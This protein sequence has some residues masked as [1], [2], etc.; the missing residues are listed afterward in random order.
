MC[1]YLNSEQNAQKPEMVDT[2]YV[3]PLVYESYSC[4]QLNLGMQ[5]IARKVL[6]VAGIQ[7]SKTNMDAVT[8]RVGLVI[9]LARTILPDE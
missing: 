5:R 3:S 6:E 9:Y 1:C 8:T 4:D 7:Q 2:S